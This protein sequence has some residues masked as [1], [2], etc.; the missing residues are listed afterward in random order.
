MIVGR[1]TFLLTSVALARR[2]SEA[3]TSQRKS[4]SQLLDAPPRVRAAALQACLDTIYAR[5]AEIQAW[6]QVRPQNATGRGPLD[7]IPFGVKDLFETKGLATEYGS[8]LYKGRI[9]TEDAAIVR[10]IRRRGGILLG[11]THTTPFAYQPSAPTRNPRNP[12]YSPGGSSSGSAAAVAAGMVP[13]ALGTQTVG[14]V[15]RPA[16]YCGVVGF[17]VSFGLLPLEGVFP[18]AKSLDTLGFFTD[19]ATDMLGF[20][21]AMG[22]SEG[23]PEVFPIA[24]PDPMPDV[25]VD[26]MTAFRGTVDRLR[27]A[28]FPTQTVDI[29]P[30][31]IR[32]REAQRTIMYFEAARVHEQHYARYGERLGSQLANLVRE[33]LKMPVERYDT[34]RR[35]VDDIRARMAELFSTTP[36]ILFPAAT[37]SAPLGLASTGDPRLNGPW[38]ALGTPCVSVPMPVGEHMPLGIQVIAGHGQ[39]ARA[40]Q[41]AVRVERI[42]G[43]AAL[44]K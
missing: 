7:G 2:V 38:T 26:M 42:L 11:K 31:I 40:L 6:V 19:T 18:L 39:D 14:S 25:D 21:T 24:I 34:A 5:D 30:N 32:L 28:G 8:P 33:G 4:L 13:L 41:T 27:A 17:K 15:I 29:V 36:V 10:Q 1:R 16:S 37:G 9:G 44:T 23:R 20:W 35:S 22:Q 12:R 3:Q 43:G